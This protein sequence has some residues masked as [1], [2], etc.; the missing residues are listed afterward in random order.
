MMAALQSTPGGNLEQARKYTLM[1]LERATRPR[2]YEVALINAGKLLP[3]HGEAMKALS[4]A[5]EL[6]M[7]PVCLPCEKDPFPFA[8]RQRLLYNYRTLETVGQALL[9][10][11][12]TLQA[13]DSKEAMRK[14]TEVLKFRY[15]M[16]AQLRVLGVQPGD[17]E[18]KLFTPKSI[19]DIMYQ[20]LDPEAVLE[21]EVMMK[22]AQLQP[23]SEM[24]TANDAILDTEATK[25]ESGR[26]ESVGNNIDIQEDSVE[27]I[28]QFHARR[29]EG[30]LGRVSAFRSSSRDHPSA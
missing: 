9:E 1:G 10:K 19:D 6:L 24:E 7:E 27:R 4:M 3:D 29:L 5:T 21:E 25:Y 22:D 12:K 16:K 20:L 23:S 11:T 14:R 15:S 26:E 13:E 2:G 8:T 30:D 18:H 17:E 28:L